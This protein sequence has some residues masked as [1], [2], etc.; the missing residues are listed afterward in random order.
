MKKAIR[1]KLL[2]ASVAMAG[3]L[4]KPERKDSLPVAYWPGDPMLCLYPRIY[5]GLILSL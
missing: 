4:F 1:D 5:S 3:R 2:Q